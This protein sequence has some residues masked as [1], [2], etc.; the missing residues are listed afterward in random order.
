M[1][2]REQQLAKPVADLLR[3]MGYTVWSEVPSDAASIDLVGR[4]DATANKSLVGVELKMSWSKKLLHQCLHTQCF[5]DDVYGATPVNPKHKTIEL[6]KR[7]GIGMIVVSNDI[8]KVILSPCDDN[9]YH[10]DYMFRKIHKHLDRMS[11]SDRAGFPCVKGHGPAID[12]MERVKEYKKL[13]PQAKW[14]DVY[15]AVP[16][17]YSSHLSMAGAMRVVDCKLLRGNVDGK[18]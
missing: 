17:H 6:F 10:I 12:C 7:Y 15:Q 9:R 11:P 18:V 13:H 4:N 2:Y 16:N 8:A 3:S 14:R 1:Q 5:V